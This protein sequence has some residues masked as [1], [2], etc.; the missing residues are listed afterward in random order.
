MFYKGQRYE[1]RE[2][3]AIFREIHQRWIE[4]FVA[5]APAYVEFLIRHLCP[6]FDQPVTVDNC[7][8]IRRALQL[9]QSDPERYRAMEIKAARDWEA[10]NGQ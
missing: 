10:A 1:V 6:E 9:R 2:A 8:E 4:R 7:A 5:Q 3:D